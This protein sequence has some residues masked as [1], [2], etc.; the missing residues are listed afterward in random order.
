MKNVEG[1][2]RKNGGDEFYYR[3]DDNAVYFWCIGNGTSYIHAVIE[4]YKYTHIH[5]VDRDGFGDYGV[6][7]ETKKS[8]MELKEVQEICFRQVALELL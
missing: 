5:F 2:Y 1:L 6:D 7:V 8:I 3:I 4:I